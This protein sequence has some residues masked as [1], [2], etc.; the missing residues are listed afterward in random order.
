M[1]D[2]IL[3]AQERYLR[4]FGRMPDVTLVG[5]NITDG[6]KRRYLAA[7]LKAIAD[8]VPITSETAFGLDFSNLPPN[9]V[10]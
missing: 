4:L 5:V 3:E 7:L 10:I 9:A 1:E 8:N 6:F 2:K